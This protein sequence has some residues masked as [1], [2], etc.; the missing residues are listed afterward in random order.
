[1]TLMILLLV[2]GL[3][4]ILFGFLGTQMVS[5]RKEVYKMQTNLHRANEKLDNL[6]PDITNRET[7][8]FISNHAVGKTSVDNQ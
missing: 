8:T 6:S 5:L 7:V 2:A 4:I 1:M 3:Q